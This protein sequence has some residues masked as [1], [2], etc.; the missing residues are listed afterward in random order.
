MYIGIRSL[1]YAQKGE[2]ALSWEGVL[3]DIVRLPAGLSGGGCAYALRLQSQQ[4]PKALMILK[5]AGIET[6]KRFVRSDSGWQEVQ[7]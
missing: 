2:R 1:T 4:L 6:G 5:R 3:A 7:S